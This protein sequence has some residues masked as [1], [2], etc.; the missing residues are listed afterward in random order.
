[1]RYR[2]DVVLVEVP[3]DHYQ[4]LQSHQAVSIIKT[5]LEQAYSSDTGYEKA[6][7]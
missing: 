7:A 6:Y 1:M 5:A 4:V 3:T 2:N